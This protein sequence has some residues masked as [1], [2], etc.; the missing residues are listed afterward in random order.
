[1]VS[2]YALPGLRKP[3]Y[4]KAGSGLGLW[5][6]FRRGGGGANVPVSQGASGREAELASI[7]VDVPARDGRFPG[8]RPLPSAYA[9]HKIASELG[10]PL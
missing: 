3:A 7:V 4:R 2:E 9:R 8:L 10:V 1:M 6:T 5:P